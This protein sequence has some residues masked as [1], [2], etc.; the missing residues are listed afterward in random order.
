VTAAP[1][2]PAPPSPIELR[3]ADGVDLV[4]AVWATVGAARATV[5]LVHG[6]T[7]GQDDPAV[8]AVRAALVDAGYDVITF[9]QRGHGRSGGMSTLGGDE[10]YD[11]AAA[12]AAAVAAGRDRARPVIVVGASMGAIAGLQAAV[13]NADVAGVVAISCPARWRLYGIRSGLA[14]VVTRTRPGRWFLATANGVRVSPRWV[15]PPEPRSSISRLTVPVAVIHGRADRFIPAVEAV[16][17]VRQ[18]GGLHR[19]ELVAD[20]GHAYDPIGTPAILDAVAWVAS[21]VPI[22]AA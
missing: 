6:F 19:L 11:V 3:A 21:Q 13:G 15:R 17:L 5:V 20:M 18:A 4:G 2:S 1:P 8:V 9:D 12:V 16:E 10:R 7:A 22:A 14:A